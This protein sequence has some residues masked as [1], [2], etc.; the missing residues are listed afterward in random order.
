LLPGQAFVGLDRELIGRAARQGDPGSAATFRTLDSAGRREAW[1]SRLLR[2]CRK[3]DDSGFALPSWHLRH[4]AARLLAEDE[5]RQIR[6]RRRLW[7]QDRE[8]KRCSSFTTL[9]S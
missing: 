9:H 2:Q 7:E 8:W 5:A 3:H 6:Q 4:W 1:I